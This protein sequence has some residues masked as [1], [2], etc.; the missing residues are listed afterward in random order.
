MIAVALRC[1]KSLVVPGTGIEPV[2]PLLT[3]RRILRKNTPTNKSMNTVTIRQKKPL[4][5]VLRNERLPYF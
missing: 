1:S 2:R 3:K 4:S 5:N